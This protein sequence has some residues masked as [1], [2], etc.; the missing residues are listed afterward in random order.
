[1]RFLLPFLFLVCLTKAAAQPLLVAP[2]DSTVHLDG[3]LNESVWRRAQVATDFT[4]NFPND[5][6]R[7]YNSTEVRLTYDQRHLYIAVICYDRDPQKR[8]IVRSLRRDYDWDTNDN[9]SIYIDPFGDRTNGFTFQFTPLG[10]EREGQMFNGEEVA[11]EWDNK[12]RS[13]VR[14]FPDRWQGEMMIPFTSLRFK[15]GAQQFLMNFARNDVKNNQ[16]SAWRRVPIAYSVSALSFADTV[17]FATPLPHPGANISLIPYVTG[18]GT[19]IYSRTA[20]GQPLRNADGRYRTREFG[21]DVGFDAK[22]AI[23]PSLNLDLTVNPDFSQV[24]VDQQVT[25]LNRFELFFPERRQFFLENNDLFANLGFEQTR[26]FFSRRIGIGRDTTTGLIVQ[27]PILY[28]AR[29]SGKID[30]AWR[31]GLLN[32]RTARQADRGIAAQNYTV[33]IVQRQVFA[34]SNA[35]AFVVDRQGGGG[36][37]PFT[38]VAGGEFNLLTEDNRWSGKVWLHKAFRADIRNS[39]PY[40]TAAHGL[41]LNYTTENWE[42]E[43]A[44]EYVGRDY[45]INDVGFVARAGQWGFFPKASYKFYTK[46]PGHPIVSHG[47]GTEARIYYGLNGRL[48]D[49]ELDF[50]YDVTL[51]NTTQFG[52][53]HY[54]YYTYLFAPFDPTNSGGRPL[55]SSTSYRSRGAFWFFSSDRR[56]LL[57]LNVEGWTGT[58]FRGTNFNLVPVLSYRFQPYGS[59]AVAAEYNNIRQPEPYHSRAFWLVG[60]RLD[61]SFTRSLF[62]T[63]WL[64]YNE[65][66]RNVNLNSRLQWRFK[67][68]SD[69]FIVYTENYL[70]PALPVKNR[71]LVVKLSYWLNV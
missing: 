6:A 19:D 39:R 11:S 62:V 23:T 34:R 70:P 54:N 48:Y 59:L 1:M 71:A 12:W 10:V 24:E 69:L 49:R 52:I 7:A 68:V 3:L 60:P 56:R 65:Q 15:K 41:F 63:T 25:N 22:V 37:S 32:T 64:Q 17:R 44:H 9:I 46:R 51:R 67:P 30:K 2:T 18:R 21:S 50:F 5:T 61:L 26:P 31:I 57:T 28:G 27:N 35:V 8:Y 43:W 66:A 20:T 4:L 55:P 45:R 40:E 14:R 38:R 16:R 33:A 13:V 58:Y 42:L 53:G 29:L 47:P 36:A